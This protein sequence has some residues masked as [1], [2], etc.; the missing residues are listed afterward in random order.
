MRTYAAQRGMT[1]S[2]I[3]RAY[4]YLADGGVIT[5]ADRRRAR[6]APEGMI[7]ASRLLHAERVFRLAC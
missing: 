7:V 4:R 3:S 5:L 6:I 2:T 1:A